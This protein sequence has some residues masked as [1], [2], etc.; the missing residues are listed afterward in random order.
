MP[1]LTSPIEGRGV[2]GKGAPRLSCGRRRLSCRFLPGA[3]SWMS[4]VTPKESFPRRRLCADSGQS[5][6]YRVT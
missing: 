4:G 3:R 5:I 1:S 6:A 2:S